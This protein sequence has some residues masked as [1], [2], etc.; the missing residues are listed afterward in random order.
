[1]VT[2]KIRGPFF[3]EWY[4]KKKKKHRTKPTTISTQDRLSRAEVSCLVVLLFPDPYQSALFSALQHLEW[5][6]SRSV[7]RPL[8]I[9]CDSCIQTPYPNCVQVLP[10]SFPV[11]LCPSLRVLLRVV[12]K[13]GWQRKNELQTG[14]TYRVLH[15]IYSFCVQSTENAS[16]VSPSTNCLFA[17]FDTLNKQA[18]VYVY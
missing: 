13:S 18:W 14:E 4:D 2:E 16:N 17:L 15:E 11:S 9:F 7:E 1:M 10:F 8:G 3:I 5:P 12:V 6:L